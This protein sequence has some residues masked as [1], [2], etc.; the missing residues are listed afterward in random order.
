MDKS[1]ENYTGLKTQYFS[2]G[3]LLAVGLMLATGLYFIVTS[4]IKIVDLFFG[5]MDSYILLSNSIGIAAGIGLIYGAYRFVTKSNFLKSI[6]DGLFVEAIY[7]RLEPLLADIA[8]TRASYDVLNEKV[9]N[10]NFNINDIRK[11]IEEGRKQTDNDVTPIQYAM[12]NI[13]HQFHYIMLITVT[14]SLYLFMFNN[15]G[16][17]IPYLSPIVF[18]LWWGLITSHSNLWEEAKAWY[19]V[20]VPILFIPMYSILIT[21][22]YTPS[23]MLMVMYIGLSIYVLLYYSWCERKT[24]GILPFGIGE[25]IQNLKDIIRSEVQS[26]E[27]EKIEEQEVKQ[28]TINPY[29]IGLILTV[30]SIFMFAAAMI[31]YLMEVKVLPF[32][33]Q[34][35]GL[36]IT[37]TPFYSYGLIGSGTIFL[38]TGYFFVNKFRRK[39]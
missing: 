24:R 28:V 29:L 37:W 4:L 17:V 22:L 35:L 10:I 36:D 16:G 39:E 12:R 1:N 18:V 19:W 38:L 13:T 14:A 27:K 32:S 9:E 21:A 6:A 34:T 8:E 23:T 3:D 33:W 5:P 2:L 15:P 11:S 30:L 31:G 26:E 7:E 25:R 20:A